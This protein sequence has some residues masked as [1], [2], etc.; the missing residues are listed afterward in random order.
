MAKTQGSFVSW[1]G[2]IKDENYW[3]RKCDDAKHAT[4]NKK[5]QLL[6]L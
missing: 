5:N 1:S 6:Q 4:K 3:R 2:D